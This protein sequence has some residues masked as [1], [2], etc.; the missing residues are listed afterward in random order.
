MGSEGRK[1]GY[2]DG[3]I[4]ESITK[5]TT[6]QGRNRFCSSDFL[7]LAHKRLLRNWVLG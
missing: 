2:K 7:E 1:K 4:R 6:N 3:K 5:W